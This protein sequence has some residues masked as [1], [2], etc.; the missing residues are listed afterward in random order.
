LCGRL[1]AQITWVLETHIHNDYVSG[2][3]ELARIT[4]ARYGLAEAE[5]VAFPERRVG[6]R[7]GDVLTTGTMTIRVVHTPGHTDHH[8]AFVLGEASRGRPLALF[9]GGSWLHGTAGRT[10]LLGAE[11][12]E[13]LARAQWRS[14]RRLARELP[15][16]V[17]LRPTHG[18]GS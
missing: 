6:L 16:T 11:R 17:E 10:D 12:T 8:L 13:A 7:D 5:E 15:A 3:L 1:G 14:I 4:G 18:F 2:G 9:S